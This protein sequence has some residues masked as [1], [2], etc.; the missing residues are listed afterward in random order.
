M[1]AQLCAIGLLVVFLAA[2]HAET[3]ESILF[4]AKHAPLSDLAAAAQQ[5]RLRQRLERVYAARRRANRVRPA[6]LGKFA[7]GIV[8]TSAPDP[9]RNLARLARDGNPTQRCLL[10]PA[11]SP[12]SCPAMRSL[13]R[14]MGEPQPPPPPPRGCLAAFIPLTTPFARIACCMR[15]CVA[16]WT[17]AL[18]LANNYAWWSTDPLRNRPGA[19]VGQ[20]CGSVQAID[21]RCPAD[22]HFAYALPAFVVCSYRGGTWDNK[23][24]KDFLTRFDLQRLGEARKHG[25][26]N[27]AHIVLGHFDAM[28]AAH[29]LIPRGGLVEPPAAHALGPPPTATAAGRVG[30]GAGL[31]S[32]ALVATFGKKN[33]HS[34]ARSVVNGTES[35]A[36]SVLRNRTT[37]APPFTIFVCDDRPL[38]DKAAAR[39]LN[40]SDIATYFACNPSLIHEKVRG[41]PDGVSD[42]RRWAPLLQAQ[43]RWAPDRRRRRRLGLPPHVAERVRAARQRIQNAVSGAAGPRGKNT[44]AWQQAYARAQGKHK[45]APAPN[46]QSSKGT[47]SAKDVIK[48]AMKRSPVRGRLPAD[49]VAAP[50]P[51]PTPRPTPPPTLPLPPELLQAVHPPPTRTA[52]VFCQGMNPKWSRV[53]ALR[54]LK[55]NGFPCGEW[56]ESEKRAR[57]APRIPLRN[58]ARK[59]HRAAFVAAPGGHGVNCHRIWEVASAGAILIMNRHRTHDEMFDGLPAL[60]VAREPLA[61]TNGDNWAL[62]TA[63]LLAEAEAWFARYAATGQYGRQ[64]AF[65]P[66]WLH[67]LMQ[68][69][70]EENSADYQP[71]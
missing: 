42:F 51:R 56:G 52:H 32:G 57:K 68:F 18:G 11:Q 23:I 22:S 7:G 69:V 2:A 48:N 4:A 37:F 19:H 5:Q 43:Q 35:L 16:H 46:W 24:P 38:P 30:G 53:R 65:W 12:S 26:A 21:A 13:L 64:R 9:P 14:E 71:G 66:Y 39:V 10:D 60:F 49:H 55:R 20:N 1:T 31:A 25:L 45:A 44:P 59:M 34:L 54:A 63:E 27:P 47:F 28:A 29:A 36:L 41:Y 70:E 33:A 67:E 62:V 6:R 8:T 40:D 58:Y 17:R 3:D 61:Y 15:A 50:T